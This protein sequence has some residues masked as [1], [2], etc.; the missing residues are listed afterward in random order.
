MFIIVR[1]NFRKNFLGSWY[2]QSQQ[3]R[4]N[5]NLYQMI[6]TNKKRKNSPCQN[7]QNVLQLEQQQAEPSTQAKSTGVNKAPLLPTPDSTLPVYHLKIEDFNVDDIV[8]KVCRNYVNY[9]VKSITVQTALNWCK[10]VQCHIQK[11]MIFQSCS[12]ALHE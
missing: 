8:V 6:L 1:L 5:G 4:R 9:S 12:L 2:Y 7:L 11:S 3:E 10:L